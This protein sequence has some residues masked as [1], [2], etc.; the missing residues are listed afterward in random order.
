MPARIPA[1]PRTAAPGS[2]PAG[3]AVPPPTAASRPRT[4][5]GRMR[6]GVGAAVALACRLWSPPSP[7]T[8]GTPAERR[9]LGAGWGA[10]G[11]CWAGNGGR[12]Q[13][14]LEGRVLHPRVGCEAGGAGPGNDVGLGRDT[15]WGWALQ[16]VVGSGEGG[17][18]ARVGSIGCWP[19]KGRGVAEH[20]PCPMPT[21]RCCPPYAGVGQQGVGVEDGVVGNVIS[22]EVE[23]PCQERD[24]RACA[25]CLPSHPRAQ[26]PWHPPQN[27]PRHPPRHHGY[28]QAVS[29]SP[30]S[31]TAVGR[32]TCCSI[33]CR[34][35]ATFSCQ[36][37]PGRRVSG[38]LSPGITTAPRAGGCRGRA[39]AWHPWGRWQS[40]P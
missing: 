24:L 23:E 34:I 36:L 26:S 1:A 4:G 33:C 30:D 10:Q 28:S 9:G 32:R 14:V 35:P 7:A 21:G 27:P 17:S 5:W 12:P 11:G 38:Q 37:L 16:D 6:A 20:R 2:L 22:A 18:W 29:S 3:T 13:A 40:Y 19:W 31:S 15:Q 25:H 39:S 8:W